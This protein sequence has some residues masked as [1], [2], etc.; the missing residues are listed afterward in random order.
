[1]AITQ[2][3]SALDFSCGTGNTGTASSTITVPA[4]AELVVVGVSG[5]S[6]TAGFFTTN[7]A[8]TFT[9][10]GAD[11]TMSKGSTAGSGT[12]FYSA[13]IFY[14]VLPD[15]GSNKSLKWDWG[16][17]GSAGDSVMCSV[18]FWKGIDTASPVRTSAGGTTSAMPYTS[19]AFT[20]NSG[21][22]DLAFAAGFVNV[23]EGTVNS[24]SN[25]TLLTQCARQGFAD[26]AWAT[27]TTTGSHTVAASTDTNWDDGGISVIVLKPAAAG[28]TLAAEA[29]SYTVTGTAASLER[30][31]ETAADGGTYAVTGTAAN[32]ERG[33]E[34]AAEA[35]SYSVTG[36]DATFDRTYILPA[37]AGSYSVTGSDASLE[38][39]Y[40]VVAEAGS[41]TVT[42]Q[43]AT[44][45]RAYVIGAG[46]G[47][48]AVTGTDASLEH[49]YEI[50]AEAGSYAFSGADAALVLQG[51]TILAAEAGSY[52][53]TGSD[54]ALEVGREV[55]AEAGSYTVTGSDAALEIGR[56][57]AAEAGSYAFT[58]ADA[59]LIVT[60]NKSLAAGEGSFSFTGSDAGLIY[61]PLVPEQIGGGRARKPRDKFKYETPE[62]FLGI[63]RKPKKKQE[64]PAAVEIAA[65]PKPVVSQV[66]QVTL[67]SVVNEQFEAMERRRR[68]EETAIALLLLD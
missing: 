13:A 37:E 31:R 38:Q 45:V 44:F 32:L 5:F 10:G 23:V 48:Y 64:P 60:G 47:S 53:V 40:E 52:S 56:E 58:G 14:L 68:D 57:V 22:L 4:D 8:M 18:T 50:A 43:D 35:G 6:T 25:L 49:G 15:T 7:G 61:A 27:G 46:A 21:D 3:G 66:Q 62:D 51:Q 67:D 34:V 1:M 17:T 42:G 12:S 54:A 9:K 55:A 20:S 2:T 11:T 26:A 29:G 16:G 59:S 19:G 65:W 33:Y 36:T 41:Y 24:W 63:R 30:G 28:V 39:G